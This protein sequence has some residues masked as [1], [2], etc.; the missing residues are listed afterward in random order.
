MP[1]N[2]ISIIHKNAKKL[3]VF[4]HIT[5]AGEG[6]L[7]MRPTYNPETGISQGYQALYTETHARQLAVRR[8]GADRGADDLDAAV[9][10]Q[11]P[12]V[13]VLA[14]EHE[15]RKAARAVS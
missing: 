1:T 3:L 10:L 8:N 7:E 6:P 4:T 2:E 13:Q 12:A 5:S 9:G 11:L 14:A 15:C